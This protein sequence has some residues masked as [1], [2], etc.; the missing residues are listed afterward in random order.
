MHFPPFPLFHF[1]T[2]FSFL[3]LI[4]LPK[5]GLTKP[6]IKA[7]GGIRTLDDL[8]RVR[9]IGVS[10]VGATATGAILDE[11]V[12]RGIGK[13]RVEVTVPPSPGE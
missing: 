4:L 11:A 1:P 8:L 3:L 2:S 10:R 5:H 6:Q 12:R 9:A 13:E 7:A